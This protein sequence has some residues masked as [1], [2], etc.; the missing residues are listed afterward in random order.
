VVARRAE[1]AADAA[2]SPSQLM[3]L[4]GTPGAAVVAVENGRVV[5]LGH[6][7]ALGRYLVLRD[8]YGDIFTYAGL[9]SIAPRYRRPTPPG[10]VAQH[11][12]PGSA[13]QAA[14]AGGSG[15]GTGSGGSAGTGGNAGVG[16]NGSAGTGEAAADPAPT[17]P[18]SAGHQ[19]PT[20][21]S[22][23]GEAHS[24]ASA[25]PPEAEAETAA[26]GMGKVRLYAHPHNPL[27]RAAAARARAHANGGRWLPLRTGSLVT[28]G[29]VLGHVAAPPAPEAG[30]LRFAVRPA[31]DNGT[32]DPRALLDN[33]RELTVAMHPRGSK[34]DLELLGATAQEVFAMSKS[35]LQRSVLSDPGIGL[36]ACGRRD[37]QEGAVDRR[38]LGTLE[39]L[40]RSG[41]QPTVGA[42][43]CARGRTTAAGPVF[44][45]FAGGWVDIVA[46]NGIPIAGHQGPRSI[47]DATI[48]ALL[49]LHGQWLPSRI[50]SLM[51]YPHAPNT[52]AHTADWNRIRLAFGSRTASARGAHAST[53]RRTAVPVAAGGSLS[54]A[55]WDRL[56][57]RIAAI[58]QPKVA[59]GPSSSAIRDPQAA[60]TNRALGG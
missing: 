7:R 26:G 16:G 32:V 56:I 46:I 5:H 49:T 8:V 36:D 9:G 4:T 33:W 13:A 14:A 29:T 21:L 42:L 39:F 30:R 55:Q 31:G 11:H 45:H 53:A 41:L 47:T 6:S 52:L 38:V 28:Q 18:A 24:A 44:E 43:R 25:P 22:V 19:R 48:R 51:E 59:S 58:Q 20:T 27:A 37:V 23:K 15:S 60:L 40:S 34:G 10:D 1:A 54:R 3:E 2:A 50:Y 12:T 35:E 57:S 17:L